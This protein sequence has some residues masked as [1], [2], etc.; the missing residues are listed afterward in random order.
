MKEDVEG[1]SSSG[2]DDVESREQ[3]SNYNEAIVN[4]YCNNLV[5]K[6]TRNCKN[7]EVSCRKYRKFLLNLM[8]FPILLLSTFIKN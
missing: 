2:G 6:N 3:S 8:G 5:V 1:Y 7:S 4:R